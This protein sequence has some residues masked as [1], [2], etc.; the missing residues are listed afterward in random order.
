VKNKV[1]VKAT[2]FSVYA[3]SVN[4]LKG[5]SAWLLTDVEAH[6]WYFTQMYTCADL[7]Q[8]RGLK[9]LEGVDIVAKF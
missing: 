2:D 7:K 4:L 8:K 3:G 6:R 9:E 5:N 1:D